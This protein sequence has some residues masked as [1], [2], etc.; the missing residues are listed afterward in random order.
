MILG[1]FAENPASGVLVGHIRTLF[2]KSD[3]VVFEPIESANDKAPTHRVY[4]ADEVELGAAWR[5]TAKETGLVYYDVT[6]DDPTFAS[7][8]HA[9][10]VQAKAKDASG[11]ILVWDRASKKKI[12]A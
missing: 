12:A 2:F 8:V 7:A 6:L 10:L 11:F 9:R 3:K 5:K 1:R 4:S